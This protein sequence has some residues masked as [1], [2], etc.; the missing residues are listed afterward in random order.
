MGTTGPTGANFLNPPRSL[1]IV[2]H[3][4]TVDDPEIPPSLSSTLS[5][6]AVNE[7]IIRGATRGVQFM[8]AYVY[9]P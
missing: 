8:S 9:N 4:F 5:S 3:Y 6:L 1:D 7:Y 2:M